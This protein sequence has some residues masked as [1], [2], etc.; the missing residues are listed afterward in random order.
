MYL[1]MI[2]FNCCYEMKACSGFLYSSTFSVPNS[3]ITV[4]PGLKSI[5]F[6]INQ[7][8]SCSSSVC[9]DTRLF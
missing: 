8:V 1:K 9:M 6:E 4:D 3:F 5:H 7:F 2:N